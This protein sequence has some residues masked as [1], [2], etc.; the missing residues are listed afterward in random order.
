MVHISDSHF[1]LQLHATPVNECLHDTTVEAKETDYAYLRN[2][3]ESLLDGIG[4]QIFSIQ[5]EERDRQ[6]LRDVT[7]GEDK[8]LG[9]LRSEFVHHIEDST[10]EHCRS[11]VHNSLE[12]FL[13]A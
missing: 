12:E 2:L 1:L 11:Y 4:K 3:I 5:K 6:I 13:V 9:I 7:S 10:R 8:E